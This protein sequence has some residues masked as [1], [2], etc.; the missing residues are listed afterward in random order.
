MCSIRSSKTRSRL[1]IVSWLT[2]INLSANFIESFADKGVV[3]AIAVM[4][5]SSSVSKNSLDAA[6]VVVVLLSPGFF[7]HF[8]RKK[9]SIKGVCVSLSL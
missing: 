5:S 3:V 8:S 9:K 6:S 7:A 4:M 2:S 1:D